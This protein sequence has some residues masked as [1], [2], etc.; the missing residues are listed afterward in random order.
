MDTFFISNM[1]FKSLLR[2][3][4]TNVKEF[5]NKLSLLQ[6]PLWE[7][8]KKTK[9]AELVLK[10]KVRKI[11]IGSSSCDSEAQQESRYTVLFFYNFSFHLSLNYVKLSIS[12]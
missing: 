11:V 9:E 3:E 6:K 7:W 5:L 1:S 2:E 12:F 4:E 10:E 8:G